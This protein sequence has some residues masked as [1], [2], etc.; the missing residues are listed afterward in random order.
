[1]FNEGSSSIL[2]IHP[3][4]LK[5]TELLYLIYVLQSHRQAYNIASR[6]NV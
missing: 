4:L 3:I 2:I 5:I 1:M 6:D